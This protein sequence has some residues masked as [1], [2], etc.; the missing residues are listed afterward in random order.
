MKVFNKIVMS[1]LILGVLH[2][3]SE[4]VRKFLVKADKVKLGEISEYIY[5]GIL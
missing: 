2:A 1:L 3:Q 4:T 5:T